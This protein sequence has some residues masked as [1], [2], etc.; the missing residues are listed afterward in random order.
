MAS[1]H[2]LKLQTQTEEKRSALNNTY[3]SSQAA[4]RAAHTEEVHRMK[5]QLEK[6]IQGRLNDAA[7]AEG[8]KIQQDTTLR[9]DLK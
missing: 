5:E 8:W 1:H 2:T 6:Q 4:L 7:K 3:E 9:S